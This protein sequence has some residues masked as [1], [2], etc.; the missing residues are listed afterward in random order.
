[1][2]NTIRDINFISCMRNKDNEFLKDDIIKCLEIQ[3]IKRYDEIKYRENVLN[4]WVSYDDLLDFLDSKSIHQIEWEQAKRAEAARRFDMDSMIFISNDEN[5]NNCISLFKDKDN[6][7]LEMNGEAASA[8]LDKF[9]E[10]P[11]RKD[12]PKL[13]LE[14]RGQI[15]IARTRLFL[16]KKNTVYIRN[17][18]GIPLQGC[19]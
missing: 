7:C 4:K 3:N 5:F 16:D 10:Y 9:F 8:W 19:K 2:E 6:V 15:H 1:M 17:F 18:T 14:E 11:P 13:S 12:L